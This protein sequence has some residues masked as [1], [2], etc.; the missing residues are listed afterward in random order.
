MCPIFYILLPAHKAMI[1]GGAVDYL[2][3]GICFH[4][5]PTFFRKG[6]MESARDTLNTALGGTD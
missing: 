5:C 2:P 6:R 4:F 1:I 3:S